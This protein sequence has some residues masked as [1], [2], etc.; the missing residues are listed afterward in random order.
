MATNSQTTTT[1][2]AD[3]VTPADIRSDVAAILGLAPDALDADTDLIAQGL[4]SL[5]M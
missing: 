4:D 1:T 5:R 2:I 3:P